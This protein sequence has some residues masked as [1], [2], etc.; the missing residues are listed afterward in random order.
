MKNSFTIRQLESLTD[1]ASFADCGA[2][3]RPFNMA[4]AI[5][6][7]V[8]HFERVTRLALIEY[9]LIAGDYFTL[10]A[11]DYFSDKFANLLQASG[12]QAGDTV[13]VLLPPCAALVIAH[14]G[15][16]KAACTVLP[17]TINAPAELIAYGLN[18]SAPKALV[19]SETARLTYQA[20]VDSRLPASAIFVA[21]DD[22]NKQDFLAADRSFWLAVYDAPSTF[23]MVETQTTTAA[24]AFPLFDAGEF[25]M[26]TVAHG[27]LETALDLFHLH[28]ES[29]PSSETTLYTTTGWATFNDVM[30]WLYPALACGCT[31]VA[32]IHVGHAHSKLIEGLRVTHLLVAA[33]E[34]QSLAQELAASDAELS[35]LR[36]L[37]T[38]PAR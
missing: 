37:L 19:T 26:M 3:A 6:H 35:D 11:L 24:L 22:L 12:L 38:W 21:T 4:E 14:L 34:A 29:Q 25:Q 15:A 27:A 5:C 9:K 30:G 7:N 23:A 17:L 16:L 32:R 36:S 28:I 31:L 20:L 33:D 2:S 13:A 1:V 10:N 8:E 18:Q